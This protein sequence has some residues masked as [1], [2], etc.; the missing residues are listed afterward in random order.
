MRVAVQM[1]PLSGIDVSGDSSWMM[2]LEALRRDFEVFHYHPDGLCFHIDRGI[3]AR[4]TRL[5]MSKT[6]L[7]KT[8]KLSDL[9]ISEP[10]TIN[11]AEFDVVL[12]RQDPPFDMHY[13]SATYILERLPAQVVVVNNPA[14]VRN[15]PEKIL[16][17]DFPDLMPPTMISAD[18]EALS[19]FR[20]EHQDV[21]IKPLYGNG[22]VG[23]YHLRP[24]DDNLSSLLEM[25]QAYW[26]SPVQIQK[27]LPEVSLGDKR[28]LLIDGEPV[29]AIDRIPAQ[30][31]ARANMHVGGQ[32]QKVALSARDQEIC[33]RI[34][35]TL[36]GLGMI[37]VGI[38][39]IG[40]Y[41]TEI[42]VTS[43]TGIQE[44]NRFNHVH[45]EAM[46]WDSVEQHRK[47]RH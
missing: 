6:T 22:G 19:D 25:H 28:I 31:Q 7:Q 29:G 35:P 43:P 4:A 18:P 27:F 33:R 11:L 36:R 38:D 34:G 42:N 30:G 15:A 44:I 23:I 24:E 39:V 37:F 45:I 5:E 3:S 9:L 21:I 32:A 12:M 47:N 41:L 10:E 14:E 20:A 17:M 26:H 13:L 40:G 1:D 16:A 8:P 46:L 2:I